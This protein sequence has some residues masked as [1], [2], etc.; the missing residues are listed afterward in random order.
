MTTVTVNADLTVHVVSV[1]MTKEFFLPSYNPETMVPFANAM[2]AEACGY[3]FA[4]RINCWVPYKTPEQREQE[5]HDQAVAGVN[6]HRDTLFAET[7]DRVN[8]LW[9][10]D[11]TAEQQAEVTDFRADCLA[12]DQQDGYP[13]NVVW[14]AKPSVFNV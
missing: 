10:N 2:E 14:P 12:V 3:D 1:D 6:A 9:W 8:P 11:M 13:Y 5:R 4:N 7:V